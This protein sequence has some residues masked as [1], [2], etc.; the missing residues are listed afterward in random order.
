MN[1]LII[2]KFCKSENEASSERCFSCNAPLPKIGVLS[3]KTKEHVANYVISIEKRLKS[4]KKKADTPLFISFVLILLIWV[5][6]SFISYK[7]FPDDTSIIIT[8]AIILGIGFFIAWGGLIN[9]FERKE[10]SK[11]FNANIKAEIIEYLKE[12]S[13][14]KVN[15]NMLA[16]K[17]LDAKSLLIKFLDNL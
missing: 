14:S 3:E 12:M 1:N 4:E 6:V 15:F 17:T 7:S 16:T 8:F 2:C 10:V 11:A 5:F 9:Y 13:I